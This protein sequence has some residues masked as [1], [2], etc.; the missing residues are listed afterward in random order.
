MLKNIL[1]R[2]SKARAAFNELRAVHNSKAAAGFMVV[3]RFAENERQRDR[4]ID[5]LIICHPK[6]HSREM[7]AER[8]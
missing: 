3:A 8:N 6:A 7:D 1:S 5:A 4:A 2:N